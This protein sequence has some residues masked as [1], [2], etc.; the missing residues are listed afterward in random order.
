[1]T[2]VERLYLLVGL[3]IVIYG[4]ITH[5]LTVT[6]LG[7]AMFFIGLVP[8][9]KADR[10]EMGSPASFARKLL[11]KWLERGEPSKPS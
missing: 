8:V 1:M 2:T 9:S 4:T 6:E 3:G 5:G 7:A 10:T 11:L